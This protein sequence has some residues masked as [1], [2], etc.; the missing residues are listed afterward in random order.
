MCAGAR[1]I[2]Y[3]IYHTHI[4]SSHRITSQ[5][6][7]TAVGQHSSVFRCGGAHS[8]RQTR[9]YV[10]CR[11]LSMTY[12]NTM[13]IIYHMTTDGPYGRTHGAI[14]TARALTHKHTHT[15]RTLRTPYMWRKMLVAIDTMYD[16]RLC[17]CVRT[18]AT[19]RSC[20]AASMC[21]CVC[22][23]KIITLFFRIQVSWR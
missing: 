5:R 15:H 23:G 1:L 2:T 6:I 9:Q 13:H 10:E 22:I 14:A 4:V 16:V 12:S 7:G 11:Y 3:M 18:S 20:V 17:V 19:V 21:L 8:T